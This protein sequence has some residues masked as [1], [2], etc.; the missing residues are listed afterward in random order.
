MRPRTLLF[1]LACLFVAGPA[2]SQAY[3]SS[4]D[5][6]KKKHKAIVLECSYPEEAAE[7]A[8]I[9]KLKGLGNK[10]RE[11]KGMFNRDKGFII[12][13]NAY[14]SDISDKD[15]D[16]IVKVERKSRKEKD[17][18]NVYLVITKNGENMLASSDNYAE[19]AKRFLNE[20]LPDIEVANLELK[21][22][23]Q[24]DEV[25]KAE[26]KFKDLQDDQVSME[27]KIKDLQEDLKKNAKGQE[28]QQKEIGNQ[29]GLLDVLKGKRKS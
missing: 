23:S 18:T 12:F 10:S 17:M 25:G 3:E 24:E 15:M 1:L 6:N 27:K 29:R 4:I 16:F 14:V 11:E 19:H 7:N 5:Y 22:K 21:I 26:K 13:R 2:F 20:L 28:D 9:E 8:I